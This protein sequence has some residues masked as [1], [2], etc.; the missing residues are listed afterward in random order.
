MG[1]SQSINALVRRGISESEA[2][3]LVDAGFTV[4]SLSKADPED[5]QDIVEDPVEVIA[6][7]RGRKASSKWA[8]PAP[9]KDYEDLDDILATGLGATVRKVCEEKGYDLPVN[10]M[11]EVTRKLEALG[12]KRKRDVQNVLEKVNEQY[13]SHLIDPTEAVGIVGAQS[14]GEPGTQMTMRTFHYAGVAEINVTLGLPRLIEIVDARSTPS[15][16]VME[17]RLK[18]D[19]RHDQ[20]AVKR[21]AV[22]LE[23]T[24]LRSVAE[25]ELHPNE[26]EVHVIPDLKKIEEREITVDDVQKSLRRK[27]ITTHR[28]GD[29]IIIKIEAPSYKT[30][31]Q[32]FEWAQEIVVSG[33]PRIDRA[34]IRREGDEYV[35]YTEGSNLSEILQLDYIDAERTTTNDI[36]EISEVLGIEAARNAIIK[37]ASSTLAEQGL[38]VD[39]RHIMLVADVMTSEGAV[40]A[41]GRH[42][43]SGTKESVL[44]RAAFEIT[45]NHLLQAALTG[46]Y[47]PLSGVAENIIVGQPVTV[48][49]GAIDLV[50]QSHKSK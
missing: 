43:I 14:I 25:L 18:E 26:M 33:I 6:L 35:I 32:T 44:A 15:T 17:I 20:E 39:I 8:P 48:G 46:E 23:M 47:D 41:I 27:N 2:A 12:R 24:R 9:R 31:Q 10:V 30:L 4:T 11:V 50:F 7:V 40:W 16:P 37:E 28:E 29:R 1:R 3:A 21:K 36:M 13:V 42:G 19:I 38:N 45:T 49:T 5:I 34:I 22:T